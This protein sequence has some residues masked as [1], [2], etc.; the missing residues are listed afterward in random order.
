MN[1]ITWHLLVKA[2]AVLY[3][4]GLLPWVLLQIVSYLGMT[5]LLAR[6]DPPSTKLIHFHHR[7]HLWRG[8]DQVTGGTAGIIFFTFWP[9]GV[10]VWFCLRWRQICLRSSL[11]LCPSRMLWG[12]NNS[13]PSCFLKNR[14]KTLWRATLHKYMNNNVNTLGKRKGL[15]RIVSCQL[16]RN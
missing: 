16:W 8:I 10:N 5:D 3:L 13:K 11:L 9:G 15:T 4:L 2:E 7:L 1:G 12:K 6:S 14:W